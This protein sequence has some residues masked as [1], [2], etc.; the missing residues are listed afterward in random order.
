MRVLVNLDWMYRELPG[1][2]ATINQM[3]QIM[4]N[5]FANDASYPRV[6][7][8]RKIAFRPEFVQWMEDDVINP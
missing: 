5:S 7:K 3:R 4:R 1:D 6:W 2:D 8:N